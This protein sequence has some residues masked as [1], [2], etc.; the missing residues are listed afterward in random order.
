MKEE[1]SSAIPFLLP[2]RYRLRSSTVR[3]LSQILSHFA[4]DD[5]SVPPQIASERQKPRKDPNFFNRSP[6]FPSNEPS[7]NRNEN[8]DCHGVTAAENPLLEKDHVEDENTKSIDAQKGVFGGGCDIF[9]RELGWREGLDGSGKFE[10]LYV[11]K[12]PIADESPMEIEKG[13]PID[14]NFGLLTRGEGNG[15]LGHSDKVDSDNLSIG[16]GR[17]VDENAKFKDSQKVVCAGSLT[18]WESGEMVGEESRV[19]FSGSDSVELKILMVGELKLE[20]FPME[21]DPIRE[22]SAVPIHN[23]DVGSCLGESFVDG[24][25]EKEVHK[26]GGN[27]FVDC[28]A[29]IGRGPIAN[30]S[31]KLNDAQGKNLTGQGSSIDW[32]LDQV[33]QQ[34]KGSEESVDIDK[35]ESE[36]LSM[37]KDLIMDG[38]H[39]SRH[40]QDGLNCGGRSPIDGRF[41]QIVGP[42]GS[43]ESVYCGNVEL[44]KL[45]T[46]KGL[47]T[48]EMPKSTN[49]EG[50]YFCDGKKLVSGELGHVTRQE[51][52]QELVACSDLEVEK[53][54][55]ENAPVADGSLEAVNLEQRTQQQEHDGFIDHNSL[56]SSISSLQKD[57][58]VGNICTSF[59]TQDG[60]NG[61]EPNDRERTQY[62]LHQEEHELNALYS[63]DTSANSSQTRNMGEVD[64]I[65]NV[66]DFSA[67]T[68]DEEMEDGEIPTDLGVLMEP[69]NS[70]FEHVVCEERQEKGQISDSFDE[71][72]E[73]F[74]YTCKE[75]L[76]VDKKDMLHSSYLTG[77]SIFTENSTGGNFKAKETKGNKDKSKKRSSSKTDKVNCAFGNENIQTSKTEARNNRVKG[78]T[79]GEL[80]ASDCFGFAE[81]VSEKIG[82]QVQEKISTA[83]ARCLFYHVVFP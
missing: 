37:E 78:D 26:E 23:L 35:L 46:E 52:R 42:E 28:N 82:D 8:L 40:T 22:G 4:A 56:K 11:E 5:S 20:E 59:D 18:D 72:G 49:T 39:I 2:S 9:G 75:K 43:G 44:E 50:G 6:N 80:D 71:Q 45:L 19:G 24:G 58:I 25:L 57:L 13:S 10:K 51:E 53:L 64:V 63:S 34:H 41:G 69:N 36:R 32:E 83:K 62:E 48:D 14:E 15:E 76:K 31:P 74:A 60:Y 27:G 7:R 65:D 3:T 29:A 54:S 1:D 38:N 30:G 73:D 66:N 81:E 55:V 70:I 61:S 17:I 68:A 47:S 16:T 33:M 79:I 12:E 21:K 67:L 77:S